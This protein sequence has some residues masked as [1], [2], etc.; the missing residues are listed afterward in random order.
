MLGTLPGIV[1]DPR[2]GRF[3]VLRHLSRLP[4]NLDSVTLGHIVVG[5]EGTQTTET[6]LVAFALARIGSSQ[7]T[8]VHTGAAGLE[9]DRILDDV[10]RDA[11]AAGVPEEQIATV[12]REGAPADV[13]AAVAEETDAGTIVV[14]RGGERPARTAHRLS[15]RAPCDLLVVATDDDDPARPYRKITVATD[16]SATADRAARRGYDLARALGASVDL[17]FVGHPATGGLIAKDTIAVYGADVDTRVHMLQGDPSKRILESAAA[18]GS[19]LVVI[20]NKGLTGIKGTMLGSIPRDVLNGASADVLVARTVRQIESQLQPGEGGIVERHG[21][22][23]AAF[24]DD[25]GELHTMSARCTHLGCIVGWNPAE[26]T[27]DCPCHGS[28]FAGNG[29]VVNGPASRP[30][31]PA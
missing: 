1:G 7:L 3:V 21:E 27:F 31:T 29:A 25:G 14:G 4:A 2:G 26:R 11:A 19:E 8:I 20:G 15:H 17:V 10:S 24:V 9:R 30:L 13:L 18:A 28:R 6:L 22:Q 5:T 16:G 23:L 12:A